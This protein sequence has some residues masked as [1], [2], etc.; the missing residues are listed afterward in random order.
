MLFATAMIKSLRSENS[1]ELS[2]AMIGFFI[3][4]STANTIRFATLSYKL[5]PDSNFF[6]ETSF[7][8]DYLFQGMATSAR[9]LFILKL[10]TVFRECPPI[11]LTDSEP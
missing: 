8:L 1:S 2:V 3:F 6:G 9:F 4:G 7:A 5:S 10:W 11:F